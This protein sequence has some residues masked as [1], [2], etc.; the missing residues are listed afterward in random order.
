MKYLM[1]ALGLCSVWALTSARPDW[2]PG[3][4]EPIYTEYGPNKEK[5][6]FC[7]RSPRE[8]LCDTNF[9]T[10]DNHCEEAKKK[11]CP[12]GC[13]GLMCIDPIPGIR[14][15]GNCPDFWT[16]P[17]EKYPDTPINQCDTD[18]NCSNPVH[19]C[20]GTDTMGI[21]KCVNPA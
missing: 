8:S 15:A 13:G 20:C 3:L 10:Q 4:P 14:R 5:E 7:P 17:V 12:V 9:C 11:C 21:R 1:L 18:D 6:G 19:K 2:I 16:V